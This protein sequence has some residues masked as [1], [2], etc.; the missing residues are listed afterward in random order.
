MTSTLAAMKPTLMDTKCDWNKR[1]TALVKLRGIV[2]GNLCEMPSYRKALSTLNDAVNV[3]LA[4]LRSGVTK[5]ASMTVA[6]MSEVIGNHFAP[7][8]PVFAPTLLQQT[9]INVKIMKDSARHCLRHVVSNTHTVKFIA[10]LEEA[11]KNKSVQQRRIS[12]ITLFQIIQQWPAQSYH[13]VVPTISKLIS[14]AIG[15]ADSR[16][17]AI[18]RATFWQFHASHPDEAEA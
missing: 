11:W 12:N 18:A 2:A 6:L 5:E 7:F 8:V 3:C 13:K 1:V 16:V 4:D 9:M 15:D 14:T 10:V 17:R